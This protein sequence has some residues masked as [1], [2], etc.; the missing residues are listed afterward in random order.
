MSNRSISNKTAL[1]IKSDKLAKTL[2]QFR[3]EHTDGLSQRDHD[4]LV[5]AIKRDGCS[6]LTSLLNYK[7]FEEYPFEFAVAFVWYIELTD[8][9]DMP[10]LKVIDNWGHFGDELRSTII[11]CVF[12]SSHALNFFESLCF[13]MTLNISEEQK[14]KLSISLESLFMDYYN[15]IVNIDNSISEL[16]KQKYEELKRLL[17]IDY[18]TIEVEVNGT[19][20]I[21]DSLETTLNELE[22]LVGLNE[23]KNEVKSLINFVK[24]NQLRKSKGLPLVSLSL[25]SVFYGPPGTGKTTIARL[26]SKAFKNLG[27]LKKGHLVETDRSQLVAGY[28]GQTA[29]KTKEVLDRALDGVLF[30]DEAY[31]LN[32]KDDYGKEAIDTILKYMEDNRDRLIVIVAGYE[33]EMSE[34][35]NSN[36]GLK[37]RFNKYFHFPNYSGSELLEI[38]INIISKN[39]FAIAE[40]AK[41]KLLYTISDA[42]F[43]EGK[44]FGNARY[45]RNLYEQ[46]IQNQFMRISQMQ[47]VEEEHLSEITI[48]DLP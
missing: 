27:F 3:A 35:I 13:I 4:M 36:T 26:I 44:Q 46:I 17:R 47:Y 41:N 25:H 12:E 40:D 15:L 38:L 14:K 2:H 16:E 29:I 22:S 19:S 21:S 7:S 37:S 45:I 24:V 48:E 11:Q 10:S 33:N 8:G 42:I 32:S 43:A 18:S 20:E 9:L 5:G 23:I 28:V 1:L 6:M 34:F 30:I 39:K 31:S